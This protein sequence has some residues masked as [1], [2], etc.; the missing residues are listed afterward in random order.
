[1]SSLSPNGN[2]SAVRRSGRKSTKSLSD[3]K[4]KVLAD[5]S[6]DP[7][8]KSAAKSRKEKVKQ[9]TADLTVEKSL[10]KVTAVRLET[11]KALDVIVGEIQQRFE[12]LKVLEDAIQ[13]KTAELEELHDKDVVL[14]ATAE[15][16]AAHEETVK[17]LTAEIMEMRLQWQREHDEY[18][19]KVTL[20]T[21]EQELTRRREVDNFQY[22]LN[23]SRKK[24]QD[25]YEEQMRV[26]AQADREKQDALN[27]NWVAREESLASREQE[28]NRQK[29]E[30]ETFEQRVKTDVAREVAIVGNKMKREHDT[31][32]E[33]LN[34]KHESELKVSSMTNE[35]LKQTNAELAAQLV[36]V[37][38]Q[39]AAA[40]DQVQTM[41]VK[42]M[43]V[44]SGQAQLSAVQNFASQTS[45]PKP[46]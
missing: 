11:G 43:E 14:S 30:N 1:M 38:A 2:G 5:L 12:Q 23:L 13:V 4:S 28:Y 39:L 26:R 15:L 35:H 40:R 29:T 22:T 7:I 45:Q 34:L 33:N 6:L 20:E 31:F 8:S 21:K 24:E 36:A 3:V 25:T 10:A 9:E 17:K 18:V 27:K 42:A 41:A 46:R 37:Q 44:Q 19:R 32:V 16:V